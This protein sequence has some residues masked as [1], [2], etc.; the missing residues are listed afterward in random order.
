MQYY[1]TRKTDIPSNQFVIRNNIKDEHSRVVLFNKEDNNEEG[2]IN[3][4]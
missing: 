4:N 3:A 1:K 2:Y